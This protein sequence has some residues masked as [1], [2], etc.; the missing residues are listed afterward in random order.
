MSSMT[1]DPGLEIGFAQNLIQS[2]VAQGGDMESI[3][4][5]FVGLVHARDQVVGRDCL[6]ALDRYI[7]KDDSTTS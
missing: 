6:I 7:S 5:A 4:S 2:Y 1:K 3:F